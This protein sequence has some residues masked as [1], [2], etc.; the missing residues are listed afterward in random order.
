MP[1]FIV[2]SNIQVDQ[3]LQGEVHYLSPACFF[4]SPVGKDTI[5]KNRI[6]SSPF[7]VSE[8][9]KSYITIT[10][11]FESLIPKISIKLNILH[12][13]NFSRL[14]WETLMSYWLVCLI[15]N[16]YEKYFRLKNLSKIF[17]D[18]DYRLVSS[19]SIPHT[20]PDDDH[21]S[22]MIFHSNCNDS[23][24]RL[25]CRIAQIMGLET[26]NVVFKSQNRKDLDY[27][28]KT[29]NNCSTDTNSTMPQNDVHI[30]M[31][32]PLTS[33][34]E[35]KK[36]YPK[37]YAS[38]PIFEY[39]NQVI[40]D[41][42]NRDQLRSI[43][44]EN[45]F[46]K[47]IIEL[48]PDYIP[49]VYIELYDFI[50][51]QATPFIRDCMFLNSN[52]YW[53]VN[54]IFTWAASESRERYNSKLVS[55]QSGGGEGL[56]KYMGQEYTCKRISDFY[57]TFGWRDSSIN[58][59]YRAEI[60][61]LPGISL[62]VVKKHFSSDNPCKGIFFSTS[63]APF[64]YRGT[65]WTLPEG[66][67]QYFEKQIRFYNALTEEIVESISYRPYPYHNDILYWPIKDDL[68]KRFHNITIDTEETNV[69]KMQNA[70]IVIIDHNLTSILIAL[71]MNSPL[72]CYWDPDDYSARRS[73]LKDLTSLR[74][75]GILHNSPEEAAAHVINIWDHI[76]DWWNNND[77]QIVRR[78]F[79]LKYAWP[80]NMYQNKWNKAINEI[81]SS[82]YPTDR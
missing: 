42:E 1:I 10:E 68:K 36:I 33:F 49:A 50:R 66:Y 52:T 24:F 60:I 40:I 13:T 23:D 39:R 20:I 19:D 48:L 32:D 22:F 74:E 45:E 67:E 38:L 71:A 64:F 72:I 56:N 31:P 9:D 57:F 3:Y 65:N 77:R 54:L 78:R 62:S 18:Q 14:Y 61:P 80:A 47:I 30:L 25:Y 5:E 35:I 76:N 16:M 21:E 29:R 15:S 41:H 4:N 55:M 58:R 79:M 59:T 44:T 75:V 46:E 43:K 28:L 81:L 8:I 73:C 51:E 27:S 26:E 82:A 2:P 70:R 12:G 37:T 34:N 63:G 6:V 17:K 11:T 69:K 7:S 53:A